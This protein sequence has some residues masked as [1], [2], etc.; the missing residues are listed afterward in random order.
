[1]HPGK[2][3]NTERKFKNEMEIIKTTQDEFKGHSVK[4]F[5]AEDMS[6]N[7]TTSHNDQNRHFNRH[8][9]LYNDTFNVHTQARC[10]I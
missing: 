1:M 6:L 9:W 2:K 5:V 8:A 7:E 10:N 4:T 3:R